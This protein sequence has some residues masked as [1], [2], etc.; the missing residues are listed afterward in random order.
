MNGEELVKGEKNRKRLSALV[1]NDI[2]KLHSGVSSG[3][4]M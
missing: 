1:L 3:G 4:D 2:G